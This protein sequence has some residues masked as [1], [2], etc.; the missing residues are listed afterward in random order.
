MARFWYSRYPDIPET[1]RARKEATARRRTKESCGAA[2]SLVFLFRN[3]GR[4]KTRIIALS[5]N[6]PLPAVAM[7]HML[8]E[9]V[10]LRR[11]LPQLVSFL[12]GMSRHWRCATGVPAGLSLPYESMSLGILFF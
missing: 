12:L 2:P 1:R 10:A 11:M 6:V 3:A 5:T 9:S 7:D 8:P 4:E